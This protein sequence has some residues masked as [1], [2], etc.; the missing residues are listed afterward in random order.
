M[1]LQIIVNNAQFIVYNVKDLQ[2]HAY[3]V[4]V[5]IEILIHHAGTIYIISK[6]I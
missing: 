6:Y 1:I 5:N 3:F 2:Y 4:L